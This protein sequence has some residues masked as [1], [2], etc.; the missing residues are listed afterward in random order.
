MTGKDLLIGLGD[1][2]Q[3]YYEEAE[4]ESLTPARNRKTFRKPFLIAALIAVTM[5]LAG[6]AVA[7]VLRLQDMSIGQETYTQY[8]DENGRAIDPTEKTRDILTLYGY[9]GDPIQ[10]ALTDWFHFL[11]TYDADGALRDNNPDHEEIPNQYEY[12][13]SCYT[14]DMVAKVDEIAR[15][16]QLKLL[17]EWIPF[18]R[19]QSGIFLEEAGISSLVLPDSGAQV[20]GMVGMAFPPHN[21]EMEFELTL[22]NLDNRL[23]VT[24]IYA[25]KD[26]F[27]RAFPGGVDLSQFTQWDATAPDGTPLLLAL[28]SN[29]QSYIIAQPENAMLVYSIDG[30]FSGSAYPQA[31]QVI[32]KAEL[33]K[34]AEVF[35]YSIQPEISDRAAVMQKLE[36]SQASYEAEHAYQPATYGSFGEYLK[37]MYAIP[38]ENLLYTFRDMN[39]D[40]EADL[41]I[42]QNGY[43]NVWVT[44]QDGE[45]R[46]QMLLNTYLCEGNVQEGYSAFDFYESH[47]YTAPVSEN[48][49]SDMYAEPEI[50]TVLKRERNQWSQGPNDFMQ[51]PITEAEA[52]DVIARYPRVELDWKPLLEYPLSETETL[53]DYLESRNTFYSQEELVEIYANYLKNNADDVIQYTHYRILDINGDGVDD[54]L[55]KGADNAFRGSTDFYWMALTYRYQRMWNLASD[56]YLCENGILEQVSSRNDDGA[57]MTG[58]AFVRLDGFSFDE[59]ELDFVVY[60]R[61]TDSWQ[62]DW[63][64]TVMETAAAE[65]ILAQYPRIDQGM[66]PISE[67]LN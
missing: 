51:T 37:E 23:W 14:S 42:G 41:L 15:K 3:K 43:Y 63:Y 18:Q 47:V 66:R 6:C 38:D 55:L 60:N 19:Y 1:I 20:S 53:R 27:P 54:L 8:F 29:G 39:G 10:L 45:T 58:H 28:G 35:D 57:E 33:E 2:S 13:Y 25:R 11:E 50:L 31:G 46:E 26:Y 52:H 36:E 64:E 4:T 56:F 30:N 49:I 24:A 9:S 48:V 22:E 5:L 16:Y 59:T 65:A 40:G 61:A 34:I 21:F 12:T 62:S 17:E 44:I 67:L 32:T 7:Y